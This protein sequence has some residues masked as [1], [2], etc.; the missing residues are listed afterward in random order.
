MVSTLLVVVITSFEIIFQVVNIIDFVSDDVVTSDSN[1][2]SSI[3]MVNVESE[4]ISPITINR[5]DPNPKTGLSNTLPQRPL[6]V[7]A[8]S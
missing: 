7:S 4:T 3:G 2:S 1:S 8:S 6:D 5:I